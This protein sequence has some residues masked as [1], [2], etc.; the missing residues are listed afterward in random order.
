MNKD[1]PEN[2]LLEEIVK[3]EEEAFKQ[4]YTMTHK[5]VFHYL[6]RLLG[7]QHIVEDI[8]SQTYVEVWKTAEKFRGESRVITWIIGIARN[9]AMNELRRNKAPEIELNEEI[10]SQPSQFTDCAGS[11]RTEILR[12]AL[13]K[14]S[15]NHREVLDL[16]F[17]QGMHYDEIAQ[18][19][20]VPVN[21]VKTRVFYAKERIKD[22]FRVM[23]VEKYD[24][25]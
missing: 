15:S 1:N 12:D 4:L 20:H 16:V 23:G 22:V 11:Q 3:G 18:V 8:L 7:N 19:M 14:L 10:A 9:L 24:L 2:R 17:L 13:N 21:T 25:L 5:K 6:V